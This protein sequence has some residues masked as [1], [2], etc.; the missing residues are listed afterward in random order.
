MGNH[1]DII[2]KKAS[3]EKEYFSFQKLRNSLMKSNATKDEAEEIVQALKTQIHQGISTKKIYS[4]AYRMLKKQS[5]QNAS[6]Y[7]LKQ[8]IME[9]GPSGFPFEKYISELFKHEGYQTEVGVIVQGKCVTHE[10][11]VICRKDHEIMLMECKFK[12]IGGLSVDVKVP[13]YINSRFDDVL[14]HGKI[15]QDFTTFK[16]WIVTNSRFTD[17]ALSY[18]KCRGLNLLGWDYPKMNSLKEIIDKTGLYPITCVTS[19]TSNEKKA[20]LE[21]GIVLVSEMAKNE[22]LLYKLGISSNRIKNILNE[23]NGLSLKVK[24]G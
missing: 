21:K 22:R 8:G 16:G 2:I 7:Y 6:R 14:E 13:L 5:T 11:D 17:D 1:E 9:L 12:N 19:L 15:T 18:G 10:I 4:M 20:I 23:S 3:G 24:N